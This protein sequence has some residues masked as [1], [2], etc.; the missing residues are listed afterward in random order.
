MKRKVLIFVCVA[1]LALA[2][3]PAI[4]L[5]LGTEKKGY[6]RWSKFVLYNLD[7]AL[8]Y[9]SRFFYSLG[10]S[11]DPKQVIIGKNDWLY[12]GDQYE[13]TITTMRRGAIAEDVEA[14]KKIGFA[15]KSWEQWL[16]LKGVRLFQ[17]ML[18]PNKSTIYP[19]FLPDWA[20]PAADSVTNTLLTNVS[21]GLY[22]DTS[23]ALRTAKSEFS[24]PL[25]YQTDTHW[26]SLGAW[27]A[28]RALG[29]S[30][31]HTQTELR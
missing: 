5:K 30:V 13:K 20:H 4:N 16:K 18:G 19:E 3:V 31:A 29:K 11:T 9:R 21:Q 26:N 7:F 15:T 10:I 6:E 14:A 1:L 17:V 22:V 27:V 12:L 24:E 8:P 28:F 2:V 23:S 25:Y